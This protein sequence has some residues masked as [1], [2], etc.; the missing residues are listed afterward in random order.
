M[1]SYA[2][3]NYWHTNYRAAQGGDFHFRYVLTS[4]HNFEPANL[5]RLGVDSQRVLSAERI[6][7]QDKAGATTESLPA[8]G[9]S[10]LEIDNPDVLLTT[11]KLA[12]NGE[13]TIVRLQE[14]AGKQEQV[15]LHLSS[16]SVRSARLCNAM[17]D[18]LTN[19]PVKDQ[20]IQLTIRPYEV[21]TVRLVQ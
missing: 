5:T 12:E 17:E 1:F 11:W 2:M 4:G 19:V 15:A 6:A 14:I 20:S 7:N 8:E 10:F 16:A 21:V 9:R 13:G 3:N 18:D